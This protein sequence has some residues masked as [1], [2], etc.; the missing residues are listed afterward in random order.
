MKT[1]GYW[2]PPYSTV[3]TSASILSCCLETRKWKIKSPRGYFN[4]KSWPYRN[5]ALFSGPWVR[6]DVRLHWSSLGN[7]GRLPEPISSFIRFIIFEYLEGVPSI[8]RKRVS[9]SWFTQQTFKYYILCTASVCYFP[10]HQVKYKY[11]WSDLHINN[12][13]VMVFPLLPPLGI[14]L[15]PNA[16]TIE[17]DPLLAYL[18]T[19]REEGTRTRRVAAAV[20]MVE[21]GYIRGIRKVSLRRASIYFGVPKSTVHRHLQARLGVEP[22]KRKLFNNSPHPSPSLKKCEI[23]F[24]IHRENTKSPNKTSAQLRSNNL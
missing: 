15:T 20:S 3:L 22:R 13:L 16:V 5:V 18:P 14:D 9:A 11:M 24:L 10:S 1:R 6:A 2:S 23:G 7:C 17:S 8:E 12:L 21:R 4:W 19:I